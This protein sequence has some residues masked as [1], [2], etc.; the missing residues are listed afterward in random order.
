MGKKNYNNYSKL[1]KVDEIENTQVEEQVEEI[2]NAQVEEIVENSVGEV[3]ETT[4][5]VQFGV[6]TNC[7]KLRVR[8]EPNSD[9]TVLGEIDALTD[10]Q[11]E[12]SE[13]TEDFYKVCTASGLDGYCM[14][15]FITLK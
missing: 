11:V 12:M 3:V 6:V 4:T 2:E 8:Q 14:K 5:P 15:K 9:A 1:E 13:S 7:I 10:V